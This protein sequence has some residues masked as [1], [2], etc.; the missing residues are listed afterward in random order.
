[1]P[2]DHF[3]PVEDLHDGPELHPPWE[4]D[5][6]NPILRSG[7]DAQVHQQ[8]L[9]HANRNLSLNLEGLKFLA[10]IVQLLAH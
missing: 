9:K 7:G 4:Q 5:S 2:A 1:V 8:R 10:I 6:L 3:G